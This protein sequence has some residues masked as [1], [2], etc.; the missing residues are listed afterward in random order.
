MTDATTEST[1]HAPTRRGDVQKCPVCGVHVDPEAYYCPQCHNYF[2]FHC[3]ARV[4]ASDEQ[5]QCTDQACDYYAKLVC[6]RCDVAVEKAESPS[7][8]AEPEDGYW[9]LLVG[10]GLAA[11]ILVGFVAG[12]FLWAFVAAIG[13]TLL[14]GTLL[15]YLQLNILGRER[16][17]VQPRSSTY[18][19]CLSCGRA[20]KPIGP[21][22]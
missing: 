4:T 20:A 10:V 21:P 17:V 16:R 6:E 5:F 22:D 19:P 3:R 1:T 12:S 11:M 9:P 18:H 15:H 8:Y 7:V 2:C 14:G 13:A